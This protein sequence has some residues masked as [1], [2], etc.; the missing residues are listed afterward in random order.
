MENL[1]KLYPLIKATLK[2]PTGIAYVPL[3]SL[4][5]FVLLTFFFFFANNNRYV[6]AKTYYFSVGGGCR[7]F[8]SVVN[9]DNTMAVTNERLIKGI[10]VVPFPTSEKRLIPPF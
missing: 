3:T 5:L 6:A 2:K 4:S 10:L 7:Q 1:A 9:E 8:E